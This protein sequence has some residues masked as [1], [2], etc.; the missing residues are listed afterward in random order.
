MYYRTYGLYDAMREWMAIGGAGAAIIDSTV[1]AA[2]EQTGGWGE[3][4]A[5]AA[6]LHTKSILL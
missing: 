5:Q 6:D 1:Q 2:E 3:R 4:F